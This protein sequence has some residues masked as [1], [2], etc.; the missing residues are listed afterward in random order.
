[1]NSTGNRSKPSYLSAQLR[2]TA[3]YLK[4]AGWQ[5]TATL[6][7]AAA[8]EI[9][10]LQQRL[11]LAAAPAPNPQAGQAEPSRRPEFGS[12]ASRA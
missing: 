3:P 2:E 4:D 12:T 7:F 11:A 5:Q 9:E 1:M 10:A 6:L 8:D